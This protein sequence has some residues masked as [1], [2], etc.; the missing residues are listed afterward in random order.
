MKNAIAG[1]IKM[2]G[3]SEPSQQPREGGPAESAHSSSMLPCADL[4]AKTS[5]C[6]FQ[7]PSEVQIGTYYPVVSAMGQTRGCVAACKWKTHPTIC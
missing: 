1:L 5:A 3:S 6:L 4:P 7:D 2:R